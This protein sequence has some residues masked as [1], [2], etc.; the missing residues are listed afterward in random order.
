MD[1]DNLIETLTEIVDNEKI[2]KENLT[3]I[4]SLSDINH[5]KMNEHLF[6]KTNPDNDTEFEPKDEFEVEIEGIT[7]RFVNSKK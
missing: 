5:K 3:L 7:V 4:Y 2:H 6:Y 1:Y